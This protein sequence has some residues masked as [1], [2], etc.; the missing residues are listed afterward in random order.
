MPSTLLALILCL[1]LTACSGSNNL[2]LGTVSADLDAHHI[3]VTDCYR[4]EVPPAQKAYDAG[5]PIWQFTP[6]RDAAIEIH[7]D[8]LTVNGR[9]YGH[10]DPGDGVLVDHG[11]VS[12][13]HAGLARHARN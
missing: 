3:V 11:A 1:L 2:L 13:Q 6:C 7:G 9:P 12:I 8:K 10:L 4:T 5:V